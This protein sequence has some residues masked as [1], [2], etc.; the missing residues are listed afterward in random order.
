MTKHT[1]IQKSAII[2]GSWAILAT[3]AFAG[4]TDK[5]IKAP[6]NYTSFQP[7]A[8]G[9]TYVDAAFGTTV[10]RLSN[11][12]ATPNA[13]DGGSVQW[14]FPEYSTPSTWNSD[15]TRLLLQHQGY[16]GLYDGNGTFLRNASLGWTQPRQ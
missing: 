2:L 11:A 9:S 14:I 10:K 3:A 8:A 6:S 16:F 15:N 13:A 5:S 7:P 1:W 12:P 4:V